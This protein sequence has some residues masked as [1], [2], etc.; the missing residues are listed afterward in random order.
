MKL[1]LKNRLL[2]LLFI[3][4]LS[5]ALSG[6]L[7]CAQTITEVQPLFFG[8]IVLIDTGVVGEVDVDANGSY[9]HNGNIYMITDAETGEYEISGGPNNAFYTLVL[10]SAPEL[11]TRSGINFI[12]DNY[13]HLPLTLQTDGSGDSTFTV[14]ARMQSQTGL[15][16]S[17]G[18]YDGDFDITVNW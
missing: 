13:E 1:F 6:R 2:H 15:T 9:S 7:A 14:G 4:T 11:M 10:P 16:Y 12:V 8:E 5:I 17:D 18:N 3:Y